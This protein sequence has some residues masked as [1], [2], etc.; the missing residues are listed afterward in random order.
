[1]ARVRARL[2][3][4][5]QEHAASKLA[6]GG[7]IVQEPLSPERADELARMLSL[8]DA[9]EISAEQMAYRRKVQS[10]IEAAEPPAEDQAA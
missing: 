9:K 4:F 3:Q 7:I 5:C 2:N 10:D 8:P 6:A 1:M